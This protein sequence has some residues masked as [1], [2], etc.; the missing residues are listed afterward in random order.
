MMNAMGMDT[1]HISAKLIAYLRDELKNPEVDYAENLERLQGGYETA[2]YRFRLSGVQKEVSQ[3][4]VLRLY[5][6]FYGIHNAIWESKVQN[7]LAQAGYPV[8][9]VHFVCTDMNILGGA[10][11]IMDYIPGQTLMS[12]RPDKVVEILGK[13][14]AALHKI[15]PMGLIAGLKQAGIHDYVYGLDAHYNNLRERT[16]NLPWIQVG[17]KWLIDQRP[18]ASDQPC[19]CH[20][21]FHPLN[22]LIKGGEVTG[23]LDWA[24]F[25]IADPA[26][27]VANTLVLM[28]I[29]VK[30]LVDLPGDVSVVDWD[31]AAERYLSAYQQ[32]K[33]LDHTHLIYY[34]VRR[35]LLALLEGFEG[36]EVWQ[37]PLIVRDLVNY[38]QITTGIHIELPG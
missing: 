19:V 6:K 22:I 11:F 2:I 1:A 25:V 21:D 15:D 29:P 26:F 33:E 18:P 5:P 31:L 7:V 4:M 17:V 8:A 27:D 12:A 28:T 9:R 32:I 10:F 13:T 24:G 30:H 16:K 36:Q 34:R 35:C 37:Q 3:S 14:H 23:V 38:I 20:G